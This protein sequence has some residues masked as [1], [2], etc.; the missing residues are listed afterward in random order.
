MF[1]FL[2]TGSDAWNQNLTTIQKVISRLREKI[3]VKIKIFEFAR[4]QCQ[5]KNLN[6]KN[7][8]KFYPRSKTNLILHV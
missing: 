3:N 4:T 5:R 1:Q 6:E 7:F 8:Q 2:K